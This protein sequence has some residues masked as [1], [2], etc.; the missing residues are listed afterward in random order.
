M[1]I[2]LITLDFWNTVGIPNPAF[3]EARTELLALYGI[4]REDYNK[5][6]DYIDNTLARDMLIA[7]TPVDSVRTLF[8]TAGQIVPE[9]TIEMVSEAINKL[10]LQYPPTVYSDTLKS[11]IKL[12]RNHNVSVML[13]SNTNFVSPSTIIEIIEH[14][15]NWEWFTWFDYYLCSGD[16]GMVKPDANFFRAAMVQHLIYKDVLPKLDEIVHIGDSVRF[17]IEGAKNAGVKAIRVNSNSHQGI[18]DAVTDLLAK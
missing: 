8:I 15:T 13:L 7:T 14:Q 16:V 3:A 5:T 4:T 12:C 9:K 10:A 11:A 17:D 18:L 6:K 1:S 2:K